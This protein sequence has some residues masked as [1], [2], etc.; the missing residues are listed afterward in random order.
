V[1]RRIATAGVVLMAATAVHGCA[2][3]ACATAAALEAAPP[4]ELTGVPGLLVR[5]GRELLT[6]AARRRCAGEP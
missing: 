1:R 3:A 5:M 2:T 6:A 4:V